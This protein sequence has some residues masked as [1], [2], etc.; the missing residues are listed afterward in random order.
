MTKFE[1]ISRTAEKA[2]IT[3]ATAE[4][5]VNA[6]IETLAEALSKGE[7]VAIPGLGVFSVKER[8]ARKGRDLRTGKE[9]TIPAKKAVVFTAAKSL[10]EAVNKK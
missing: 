5:V 4:K 8:K 6:V 7:R 10:K 9:I 1:L 3:K 2:E